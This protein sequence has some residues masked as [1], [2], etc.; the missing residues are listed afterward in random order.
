MLSLGN[1][2]D[3]QLELSILELRGDALNRSRNLGVISLYIPYDAMRLD[4]MS[5]G[6]ENE[7]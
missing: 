7:T 6:I 5:Y 4:G 1:L 2:L 3:V